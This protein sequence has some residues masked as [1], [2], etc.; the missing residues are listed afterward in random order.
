MPERRVITPFEP[1]FEAALLEH[2]VLAP[3]K[4]FP[5]EYRW[6]W[7]IDAMEQYRGPHVFDEE[8]G[9]C[10]SLCNAY[11]SMLNNAASSFPVSVDAIETLHAEAVKNVQH[12]RGK[13][14]DPNYRDT[15]KTTRFKLISNASKL[16]LLC[17]ATEKG[18]REFQRSIADPHSPLYEVGDLIE[19]PSETGNWVWELRFK[20][21]AEIQR[22]VGLILERYHAE[23]EAA[24]EDENALL[25][26]VVVCCQILER[27]HPFADGNARIF[28]ILLLNWLL[29][30]TG[31]RPCMLADPNMFDGCS[32]EEAMGLV[33]EGQGYFEEYRAYFAERSATAEAFAEGGGGSGAAVP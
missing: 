13:S 11:V 23:K 9:Y 32:V 7:V 25:R 27:L 4:V 2:P 5:Q 1:P 30:D 17:N 29:I 8:K 10:A 12:T 18:L 3:F 21:R 28:C 33:R 15:D 19:N 24:G 20:P 31:Q 14:I 16:F 22:L 6:L 26:A